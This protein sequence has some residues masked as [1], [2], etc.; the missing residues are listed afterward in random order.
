M[1]KLW[2]AIRTRFDAKEAAKE[3]LA[4]LLSKPDNPAFQTSFKLQMEKLLGQ[5]ADFARRIRE[6]LPPEQPSIS[7]QASVDGDGT[8]VQGSHNKVVGAG[9]IM[10]GGDVNGDIIIGNSNTLK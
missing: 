2:G 6:L 5:D 10:V 1:G 3:A 4:D 8:V 7:Y 9:G